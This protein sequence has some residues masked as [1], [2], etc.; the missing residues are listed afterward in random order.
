M[1]RI[2]SYIYIRFKFRKRLKA[3]FSS[4][5]GHN[6]YFEGFNRLSPQTEFNGY[7]GYGSYIA[8]SSSVFGKVGRF[9]SI[10]PYVRVNYGSHPMKEPFVS[11]HPSFYSLN[12]NHFQNGGTFAKEQLFDELR[13]VDKKNK[14]PVVIG[15]DCWIGEGVLIIGGVTISD[16]AVVLARAVVTKNIP[17]YSIVGGVPAKI[18]GYRYDE[19]TI[20]FL[21]ESEWWN[22][23]L[24]WLKDNWRLFSNIED[25]KNYYTKR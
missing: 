20:R 9:T 10:G 14:Y 3:S 17:P 15:S 1:K 18:L 4:R 25:F 19:S 8:K 6:S 11:T 2:L 5:I 7:L 13:Y 24:Q 23:P 21:L 16:G 22:M 12:S